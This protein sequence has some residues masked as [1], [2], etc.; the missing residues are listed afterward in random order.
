LLVSGK[1]RVSRGFAKL[2]KE[3]R[4]ADSDV[5]KS[6]IK[7]KTVSSQMFI[8]SFQFKILNNITF[9]KSRLAK[10]SYVQDDSCTFCRVSSE[11]IKEMINMKYKTEKY[12]ALENNTQRKF[13]SRWK[14]FFIVNYDLL[15]YSSNNYTIINVLYLSYWHLIIAL[16]F[17]FNNANKILKKRKKKQKKGS[18]FWY[19]D[20]SIKS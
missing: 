15:Y 1:V 7:V 18:I 11:M 2:K 14:L 9:T 3:S 10:I 13:Q 8:R 5:T 19:H 6:F 4:S 17:V 16:Y 20:C 12:I